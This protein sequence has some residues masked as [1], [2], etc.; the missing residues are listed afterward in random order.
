MKDRSHA[1]GTGWPPKK[2]GKTINAKSNG[3]K[4]VA[5]DFSAPALAMA[6]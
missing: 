3:S 6:A 1:E 4:V 5:V 2:T